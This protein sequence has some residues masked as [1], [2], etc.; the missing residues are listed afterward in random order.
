FLALTTAIGIA[1]HAIVV[2]GTSR[3]VYGVE[4][5][6]VALYAFATRAM[7]LRPEVDA[8]LGL[9]YGFTLLGVAAIARR[10]GADP[11]ATATRRVLPFL[12]VL[13]AFFTMRGPTTNTTA[14]LA[15]GSSILYAVVAISEG[16]RA[17]ASLAAASAN[18]ALLVFALA[19][20]LDGIEIWLGPV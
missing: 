18:L 20:G 17:F 11:V 10:R 8:V 19:E 12:P 4:L 5:L 15:F 6:V 16:S 2:E 9:F 13:V 14:M 1:V 7:N 3:H